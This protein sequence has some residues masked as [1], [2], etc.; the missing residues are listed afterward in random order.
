MEIT[1]EAEQFHFWEYINWI[2]FAVL[3]CNGTDQPQKNISPSEQNKSSK[4]CQMNHAVKSSSV[5][6]GL[7]VMTVWFGYIARLSQWGGG[8]IIYLNKL[9]LHVVASLRGGG[10][11]VSTL[12]P[13]HYGTNMAIITRA[14]PVG[15]SSVFWVHPTA[16]PMR[17]NLK[18]T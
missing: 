2:F 4:Y 6:W 11:G 15:Q 5:P 10:G 7:R 12:W 9:F 14:I 13:C 16:A 1:N 18:K 3:Q 8:G 17:N